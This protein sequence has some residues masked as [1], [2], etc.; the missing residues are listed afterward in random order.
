MSVIIRR[1]LPGVVSLA[2][3]VGEPRK[4]RNCDQSFRDLD[5][6]QLAAVATVT[7]RCNSF[8]HRVPRPL[9]RGPKLTALRPTDPHAA[10]VDYV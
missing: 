10:T 9:P 3:P 2:D 5:D 4:R 6:H 7:T 8:R 1:E